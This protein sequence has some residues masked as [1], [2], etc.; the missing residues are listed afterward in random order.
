MFPNGKQDLGSAGVTFIRNI[1]GLQSYEGASSTSA[2]GLEKIQIK[3]H[4]TVHTNDK[5]FL[6]EHFH[7]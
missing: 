1:L 7:D 3:H 2:Q 5:T 6:L 4:P